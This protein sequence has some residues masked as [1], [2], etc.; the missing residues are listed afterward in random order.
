MMLLLSALSLPAWAENTAAPVAANPDTAASAADEALS[1]YN[2]NI[3]ISGLPAVTLGDSLFGD[4][5][6]QLL[7]QH[8]SLI[9]KQKAPNLDA[10]QIEFL[11]H[12][13]PAEVHQ[14]LSTQGF[15]NSK[16]QIEKI[17]DTYHVRIQAGKRT[18]IDNVIVIL[19]GDLAND[20]SLPYYY[21]DLFL[22]WRLPMGAPFTQSD[23]AAS[24]SEALSV[25]TRKKY[26][27]ATITHSRAE[28]DP[29][30][31]TAVVSL[32]IDSR[33]PVTFGEITIDGNQRYP[34]SIARNLAS[35]TPGAAY[36]RDKLLDYQQQLEQD[37]HYG[38]VL[39]TTDFEQMENHRVPVNV[40]VTEVPRQK[41]DLG[42]RYDAYEGVGARVGY[43]HYNMF[44]RGYTGSVVLDASK[45]NQ[46]LG[47]GIS[48]PRD[49]RGHFYT[50]NLSFG[51]KTVQGIQSQTLGAGF[52]R[53]RVRDGI[54]S[55]IGVEYF[56]EKE[57]VK[58]GPDLGQNYVTMLT[59]S[60]KRNRIET[61]NRPANGYYLSAKFGTT[62]GTLLS[63]ANVQRITAD[64]AY[65][66]TP[67]SRKWGTFLVRGA[68]G[69]VFTGE[70]NSVPTA[71]LFRTGG[72]DSVRGYNT[73][74]IGLYTWQGAVFGGKAKAV[75]SAEYQYPI[76]RDWSVAVFH[77]IGDVANRFQDMEWKHSTGLGVRWFSPIAPVV[78][79]IA[80]AHQTRKIGWHISLG[81]R[82]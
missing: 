4:N 5:A 68:T 63:S 60:W 16:T 52:W 50:T 32:S 14:I 39:V 18:H 51:N 40:T 49:A 1:H 36:D 37:G 6:K 17:G 10:D 3:D 42:L 44:K 43:D 34:A 78:F 47:L 66:Y 21:R 69:Y 64:A 48:Q 28:I 46:G 75:A 55:R 13:T 8:L 67:S 9:A 80:Y 25:V 12:E 27:L 7:Q 23:W 20:D 30:H 77:D 29:D 59:A 35:F 73:D 38:G 15:F 71:L 41:L 61:N 70:E 2:V 54:D 56:L 58:N 24:K 31:A 65:Y 45:D 57:K 76:A 26:P 33:D 53:A 72:A 11:L 79:D 22:N 81:T 19:E 62:L 74:S 82:F